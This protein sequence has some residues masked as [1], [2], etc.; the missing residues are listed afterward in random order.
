MPEDKETSFY[1]I[2]N[3]GDYYEFEKIN[4]ERC[5]IYCQTCGYIPYSKLDNETKYLDIHCKCGDNCI[6]AS[7]TEEEIAMMVY[8]KEQD[9]LYYQHYK[10]GIEELYNLKQVS[11]K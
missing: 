5:Y 3:D 1:D 10:R 4:G 2:V 11:D 8:N 9:D 6:Y 7:F